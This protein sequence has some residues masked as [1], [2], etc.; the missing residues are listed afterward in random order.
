MQATA[1]SPA[2]AGGTLRVNGR[3]VALLPDDDRTLLEWLPEA[4]GPVSARSACDGAH[5]GSCAVVLDGTPVKSCTVPV[6]S[7]D[8]AE[9]RTLDAYQQEAGAL[10][11][12]ME[13]LAGPSVFQCGYCRSAFFFAAKAL[14]EE[15]PEPGR[16]DIQAAFAGLLCRCT[17][18]Q[19]IVSAVEGAARA[20]AQAAHAPHGA[21][22]VPR[23]S[24]HAPR[25]VAAACAAAQ[26]RPGAYWLAGGQHLVPLLQ[27]SA[28]AEP[29]LLEIAGIAELGRIE[30]VGDRLF[31][32]A[33]CTHGQIAASEPVRSALPDLA[34]L[35]GKVGDIYVRARGTLGGAMV[36]AWRNGSYPSFLMATDAD[37]L[38]AGRRTFALDW[39]AERA[40]NRD[41]PPAE[42]ILGVEIPTHW[43][44]SHQAFRP[45]PARPALVSVTGARDVAGD[46]RIAVAGYGARPFLVR[47]ADTL[48]AAARGSLP[49]VELAAM[50]DVLP[51]DDGEASGAYRLAILR[52]LLQ[53]LPFHGA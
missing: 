11:P 42:L 38:A 15:T 14:L 22:P 8:G 37:V 29:S 25:T 6:A 35:A 16:D 33:G 49:D 12:L 43:Q 21:K 45:R 34:G 41:R 50:L 52:Q 30:V 44:V 48:L 39:F 31:V 36:S 20:M 7:L 47:D 5:C 2:G 9:M 23:V 32:G 51:L 40:E 1:T 46:L 28:Q 3:D 24:A 53:R 27:H 4:V 13:A 17:G 10:A 26:A 19:A 18:Y